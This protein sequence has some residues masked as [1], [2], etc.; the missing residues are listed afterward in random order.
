MDPATDALAIV[1][2]TAADLGTVARLAGVTWRRHYPGIISREQIDYMLA[3]GYAESALRQFLDV[4]GAGLAIARA[5]REPVGFAAWYRAEAAATTKLDKLYVLP[6][7]Q[8]LGVGRRLIAHV[9]DAARADRADTLILN[10][11]KRNTSSIAFYQRCGFQVRE[12]VVI[13]IGQGFFMD[14]H[15]MAKPI[16][17]ATAVDLR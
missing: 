17:R 4:P 6:E 1:A 12:S 5:G 9:E 13:D 3:R 11:N 10:V 15:V 16:S 7:V 2:A 8:G 14:D